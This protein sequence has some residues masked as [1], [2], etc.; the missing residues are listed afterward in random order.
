MNQQYTWCTRVAKH[1]TDT[2]QSV[3]IKMASNT[4]TNTTGPER[5]T[6]LNHSHQIRMLAREGYTWRNILHYDV[7]HFFHQ[8]SFAS[9]ILAIIKNAALDDLLGSTSTSWYDPLACLRGAGQC[10]NALILRVQLRLAKCTLNN[11]RKNAHPFCN[12]ILF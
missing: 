2:C 4:H 11:I 8:G 9:F 6:G 1:F 12:E 5:W 7:T 3:D 10:P